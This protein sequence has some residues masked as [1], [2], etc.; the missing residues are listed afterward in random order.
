VSLAYSS[1]LQ[2]RANVY[3]RQMRL[4]LQWPRLRTTK[5]WSHCCKHTIQTQNWTHYLRHSLCTPASHASH[6]I[7]SLRNHRFTCKPLHKPRL[8]HLY[9]YI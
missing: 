1:N 3:Y 4:T 2:R 5:V 8:V 7:A 6:H 9:T